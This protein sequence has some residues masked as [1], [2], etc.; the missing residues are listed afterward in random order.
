MVTILILAL[1]LLILGMDNACAYIDLG[2]GSYVLQILAASAIGFVFVIRSYLNR[3][4]GFFI[5]KS[6]TD[7]KQADGDK[8][9]KA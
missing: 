7:E 2:T 6:P 8:G 1:C 9:D 5:R 3:I 4:K